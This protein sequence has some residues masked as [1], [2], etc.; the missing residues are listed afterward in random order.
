MSLQHRY[1]L[2]LNPRARSERARRALRFVMDHA[3]RFAI[4]A[5]N[6]PE[7]AGSLAARFAKEGEPVVVA[8]G[9]DGTMNAVVQGLAGTETILGILPTGTMNVFAREMGIPA[10]QLQGALEVIE[11]NHVS[12][13]DLFEVNGTPFVQMAGVGFDAQVIEGTTREAKKALGPLAYLVAAVKVLGEKPPKMRVTFDEGNVA[14]GVA[15]LLGNGA[16]YGGQFRLFRE[17]DN[18]DDLLDVLVFKDSGYKLV[19]DSM[20]GLARGGFREDAGS[21]E[22]FQSS[23]LRVECDRDVPVEVDGE[24]WGRAHELSFAH[25]ERKLRVLA[26][27][28][29]GT[30]WWEQVLRNLTP[31]QDA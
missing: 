11:A 24:L 31:W 20:A 9:G 12:E 28:E 4:F 25:S 2:I 17:A 3:T 27:K 7:E 6:T 15:I 14:E 29:R 30:N 22:Y 10:D 19:V 5:S 13:V 8:A 16:L 21:V 1:P 18:A 23:G 26:P